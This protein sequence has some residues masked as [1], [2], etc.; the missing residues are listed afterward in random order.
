MAQVRRFT[1]TNANPAVARNI[2]VGFTVSQA[3]TID[4]TNGGSWTWINGMGDGYYLDVD[5]GTITTSNGFTPL[6]QSSIFGAAISGFT[7][8]DPGVITAA[9]VTAMGI[10]AAD[11][12]TVV[13]LADDGTAVTLN[14][15]YTVASVTATTITTATNTAALSVY[16]SGGF[17][18]RV[19]DT[20]S[21]PI[22]TENFAIRGLTVGTGS[23]GAASASMV[24]IVYGEESVV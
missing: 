7:N 17:A 19:T 24:M 14:G 9:N 2:D 4:I 11:T 8:A 21:V 10:V 13:G 16:V 20:N 3:T 1:W 5:A 22:P 6:A 15:D 12:I 18:Y 23:V